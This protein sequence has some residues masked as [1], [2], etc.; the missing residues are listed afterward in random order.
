MIKNKKRHLLT[1]LVM[2]S[3]F[4]ISS[5]PVLAKDNKT[6]VVDGKVFAATRDCKGDNWKF[7][8][9]THTLFLEGYDGM[10]IDLGT[11]EQAV[12]NL[13]GENK[14]VSNIDAPAILVAGSLTIEGEGSLSLSSSACHAAL[15][16]QGGELSIS[17]ASLTIEGTG[18]T[19]NT[20]YLLMSDG[21]MKLES[22]DLTIHD[23]IANS[24][25]SIGN[26]AG[27]ITITD[28]KI[29]I[30]S[31]SRALVSL[32]GSVLVSGENSVISITS[33][34]SS[35][36]GKKGL[37]FDSGCQIQASSSSTESTA[38]F[39]PEGDISI[40]SSNLKIH[41]GKTAIAGQY[42]FLTDAYL[43]D[44]FDGEIREISSMQTVKFEDQ[45]CADAE[46][47]SGVKPTPTPTSTPTPTPV[48]PTPTPAPDNSFADFF[49]SNFTTR[50]FI[51]GLLIIASAVLVIV[52][53]ISKI[54]SNR[55]Y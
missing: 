31:L 51:G 20:E 21:P 11:Q 15:Y 25:G 14:V 28:T 47:R 41:S 52:L 22:T 24:G 1:A 39:A 49:N 9:E 19:E 34:E 3:I 5:V 45:V 8:S 7:D 29:N 17:R 10:Y 33:S 12:I 4:A 43:A 55:G 38:I 42:L 30:D 48:P 54:R 6:I 2:A 36:Y 37:R 44:P 53:I 50:T 26:T 35:I 18:A 27:D 32:D 46:I 40:H 16:A 13:T 23:K